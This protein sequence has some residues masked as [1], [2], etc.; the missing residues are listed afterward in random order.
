M[1]SNRAE[2]A[3][4]ARLLG[5]AP[6]PPPPPPIDLEALVAEAYGQGLAAARLEAE[7]HAR[8]MEA[9]H[10]LALAAVEACAAAWIEAAALEL[11][12]AARAL[13][14]A[15]LAAEPQLPA[16]TLAALVREVI[17][18]AEAPGAL[19]LHP[20]DLARLPE[21][22]TEAADGHKWALVGDPSVACGQIIGKTRSGLLVA[23][24]A[25]RAEALLGPAGVP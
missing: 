25:R 23:S 19:H 5:V 10:R 8:D 20:D 24:L 11:A 16:A 21:A 13:A 18:A 9:A 15:V 4:L 3:P 22:A 1:S 7:A 2:P 14:R 6:P 12:E 17:E